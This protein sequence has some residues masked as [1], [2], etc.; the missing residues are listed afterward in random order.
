MIYDKLVHLPYFNPDLEADLPAVVVEFRDV[1]RDASGLLISSPEY[2]RGVS[3]LLKNGLDW[4]V[5]AEETSGTPV[6][7]L[8]TSLDRSARENVR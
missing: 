5:G 3:G 6:A 2:A 1:V 7:L 8:N 4:L